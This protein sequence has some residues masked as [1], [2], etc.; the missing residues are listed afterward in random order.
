[1]AQSSVVIKAN[2]IYNHKVA[3]FYYTTYDLSRSISHPDDP[4]IYGCVLGIYHANV[5]YIGAGMKNYEP[6]HFDFLHVHWFQIDSQIRPCSGWDSHLSL[7]SMADEDS[8]GFVDPSLI[9][10]SCYLIPVFS[11]GKIH[12]DRISLSCTLRDSHDW[13]SYYV[14]RSV[15]LFM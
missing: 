14:N 12:P 15:N 7:P 9:L 10:R 5:I 4:F 11:L 6:M 13:K 3:C 1:M 8:L 2:R